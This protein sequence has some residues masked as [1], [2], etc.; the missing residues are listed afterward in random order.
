MKGSVTVYLTLSLG[1]L[2]S[3]VMTLVGGAY[4]NTIRCEGEMAV[5][6]A[7]YSALAEYHREMWERYDLLLVDMSYGCGNPT[8]VN[9]QEHI[10]EYVNRNLPDTS[11]ASCASLR[12]LTKKKSP[13]PSPSRPTPGPSR[14]GRGV[15]CLRNDKIVTFYRRRHTTPLPLWEGPG[16]GLS[17]PLPHREELGVD[18]FLPFIF[19]LKTCCCSGARFRKSLEP[20]RFGKSRT[21]HRDGRIPTTLSEKHADDC[22]RSGTGLHAATCLRQSLCT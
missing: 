13:T 1:V 8:P 18:I 11:P 22:L 16:V 10:R 2:L 7:M 9:L 14:K 3:L 4:R 21:A 20:Q 5:D 12:Q 19:H 6:T 17:T 15:K